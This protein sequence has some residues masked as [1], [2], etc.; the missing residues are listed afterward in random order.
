MIGENLH[1]SEPISPAG[2]TGQAL[3]GLVIA[4]GS[5]H[6]C[7]VN[8]R[9]ALGCWGMNSMGQVDPGSAARQTPQLV[10]LPLAQS[11]ADGTVTV[12]VGAMHSCALEYPEI[13]TP[14]V[15]CW[16]H[17]SSGQLGIGNKI[18]HSEPVEL[19]SSI[20]FDAL[21][22]GSFHS[23]A[24]TTPATLGQVYCWGA[25]WTH[26]LGL[27][28]GTG[29]I[30]LPEL[31]ADLTGVVAI[32]GG[33]PHTCARLQSGKVT[34]WGKNEGGV[35]GIG[36]ENED[37]MWPQPGLPILQLN[38]VSQLKCQHRNCCV[39]ADPA[40]QVYCWGKNDKGQVGD[41]TTQDHFVPYPLFGITAATAIA[42]GGEH[43]CAAVDN[44]VLCW[45][46][47]NYD[48]LGVQVDSS[49]TNMSFGQELVSVTDLVA[50]NRHTCALTQD[51]EVYCW[52][53]NHVYQLGRMTTEPRSVTLDPVQGIPPATQISARGN[54]TCAVGTE[55]QVFCWGDGHSGQ[56]GNGQPFDA[57]QP[58]KLLDP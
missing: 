55:N 4:G 18:S 52:G 51:G 48:Q 6:V 5:S 49:S 10:P 3:N 1:Q 12:A 43:A 23:C 17:N 41:G 25:N 35:L 54:H 42:V 57:W 46:D 21:G 8:G 16:G 13:G 34:C 53:E 22:M 45:G 9:G 44:Q 47:N 26:Q 30:S 19:T 29:E 14:S 56:L 20:H 28:G 2:L 37:L 32:S 33:Q 40:G 36:E 38:G 24:I 50:G 39:I 27:G 15:W 58:V 7:A 11:S 31:I